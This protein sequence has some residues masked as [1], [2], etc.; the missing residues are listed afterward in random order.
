MICF[1]I[2]QEY[3][4]TYRAVPGMK[5]DMGKVKHLLIRFIKQLRGFIGIQTREG[6]RKEEYQ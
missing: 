3:V 1:E 6:C 5:D 2:C 4:Q